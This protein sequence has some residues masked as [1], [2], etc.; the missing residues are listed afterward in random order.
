MRRY[1]ML[2]VVKGGTEVI[3]TLTERPGGQ[4]EVVL[5]EGPRGELAARLLSRVGLSRLQRLVEPSEGD[6]FIEALFET[7]VQSSQYAFLEDS[8]D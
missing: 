2:S 3:A 7:F 1:R 8:E 6:L 4:W 5:E